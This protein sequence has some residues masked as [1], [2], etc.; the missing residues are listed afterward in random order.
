VQNRRYDA[1]ERR[2]QLANH[3]K[4]GRKILIKKLSTNI[5]QQKEQAEIFSILYQK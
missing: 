3:K 2:R 4:D 1:G 5:K